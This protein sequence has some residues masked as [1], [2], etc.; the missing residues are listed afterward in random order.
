MTLEALRRGGHFE[1][2]LSDDGAGLNTDRILETAIAAGIVPAGVSLAVNGV[3]YVIP[4]TEYR[5]TVS[6]F[7]S[8][9]VEQEAG[10][11]LLR[12]GDEILQVVSLSH[13]LQVTQA[14][15]T[16]MAI[17]PDGHPGKKSG[18]PSGVR[19]IAVV[20]E[21]D[22]VKFALVVDEILSQQQVVQKKSGPEARQIR[23]TAGGT[24]L[25]DGH[26][27]LILDTSQLMRT[28]VVPLAM[29]RAS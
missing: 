3:R 24:I 8:E 17:D 16:K 22:S 21:A 25:G 11:R 6:F 15:P 13:L 12:R 9:V 10:R 5:E 23:F 18:S 7:D 4:N 14:G 27:A 29:A 28:N 26:V 20:T 19:R 1:V 2:I